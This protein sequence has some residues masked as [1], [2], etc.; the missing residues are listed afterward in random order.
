MC[1]DVSTQ[2][3]NKIKYARHI[4]ESEAEIN[5]LERQLANR[6]W[7]PQYR[8]DGFS[9]LKPKI[10]VITSDKPS[11]IQF[12]EWRFMSDAVAK[13]TKNLNTLNA[14]SETIFSSWTYK[15]AAAERH[16]I[17]LVDGFF[18]PHGY[19]KKKKVTRYGKEL[20]D[21]SKKAY[22]YI[23]NKEDEPLSLAG[24][25]NSYVDKE[26]GEVHDTFTIITVPASP[27]L[28]KIH[29]VA[30]R[31][32]AIIPKDLQKE[33]LTSVSEEH[34]PVQKERTMELLHPYDDNRLTFRTVY[35]IKK[36][37]APGNEPDIIQE[38]DYSKDEEFIP[39]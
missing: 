29:N 10:P 38:Y 7:T 19:G 18:E 1:Y 21:F 5:E 26:T 36:K 17:I 11:V 34:D 15:H 20:I 39:I 32:P 30:M 25:W 4:G 31:M 33:W 23:E 28:S 24:L 35:N 3:R 8:V 13:S 37:D 12:F 2:L 22:Y 16:C 14:R 9:K 6:E 27:L